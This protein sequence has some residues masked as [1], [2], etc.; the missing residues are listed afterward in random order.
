VAEAGYAR[1][2]LRIDLDWFLPA[3]LTEDRRSRSSVDVPTRIST[4]VTLLSDTARVDVE[5]VWENVTR[6]HRLRVLFPLGEPV[7][8]SYASGHFCVEERP[9]LVDDPGNGWPEPLVTQQP[10]AGWVSAGRDNWGLSVAAAALPEYEVLA[11]GTIALT[12]LRAV[13]WVSREDLLSR[14]GGA[15]P[16][17]PVP[18]AQC[19]GPNFASYSIIPHQGDWLASR[20]YQEA[21]SYLTP[22]YGSETGTHEGSLPRDYGEVEL[23]GKHTLAVS[24]VKKAEDMDGLVL[25]LWN[26]V[27]EGTEARLR[28]ARSPRVARRA[29]LREEPEGEL[30]ALDVSGRVVVTAGPAEIVTVIVEF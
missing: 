5:T 23:E 7:D 11:D 1:S 17:T 9:V 20:A 12:V 14:V 6:D 27:R 28:F 18:D 4:F 8:S 15:G 16:T 19:L 22:L 30:L 2:T 24:S 26:V 21:E 13:G 29:N 10:N 25:R 3:G